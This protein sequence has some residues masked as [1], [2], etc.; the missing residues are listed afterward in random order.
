M[1]IGKTGPLLSLLAASLILTGCARHKVEE[2]PPGPDKVTCWDGSAAD[3][4]QQC[5]SQPA[6]YSVCWDGSQVTPG[7]ACPSRPTPMISNP[8]VQEVPA[9]SLGTPDNPLAGPYPVRLPAA[10]GGTRFITSSSAASMTE[11][12]VD[13]ASVNAN[14]ESL[15]PCPALGNVVSIADCERFTAIKKMAVEGNATLAAPASMDAGQRYDVFVTVGTKE[16]RAVIEE[17]ARSVGTFATGEL[18]LAPYVCA[19]LSAEGFNVVPALSEGPQ[20]KERGAAP[21]QTFK[22]QVSP[23][24]N[25]ELTLKADVTTYVSKGGQ[26]LGAVG[27]NTVLVKVNAGAWWQFDAAVKRATNSAVGLR[28]LLAIIAAIIGIISVIV[29]RIKNVGK[30]PDEGALALPEG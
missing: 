22:W 20:C 6:S 25:R 30:K 9:R 10:S 11:G 28:E 15:A 26:S 19:E 24:V 7:T 23:K 21:E 29:W 13:Y 17:R 5:P 27:T 16:Q 4:Q 3:T 18:L 1:L 14:A 12:S 2:L 8:V